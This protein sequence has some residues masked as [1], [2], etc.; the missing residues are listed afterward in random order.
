MKL[1]VWTYEGPPHVGALRVATAMKGLHYVLHAPQGD[2]Y[3]DLLFTMIERRN[4]RPPVTYTT[5]QARD[6]GADTA[7]LF[8]TACLA[9]H[10]RFRPQAMIVG[11]SCTAELIQD[12]PGGMAETMGLPVPVIPLDLPSYQRKENFGADETLF[13]LVRA[14]ARPMD[15]SAHV[16]CNLIGPTALGFRHRDDITEL[17]ALLGDMGIGVNVCAP[18]GA[19]PQ[20]LTRLGAAHFNVLMYPETGE[21]ACRWMERELGQPYTRTVPIGVGATRDFLGE[22]AA[23]TGRSLA[24]DESRLRLP[25]YSAS[26]DSTYLTGKR[27]FIFGD[28]THVASAARI[29]RDEMGFEVAG[30]GC[31]NREQARMIRALARDYG[32]EALITED[33]LEVEARIAELAPEMILGTQMERHIGKRLGIPC[34]VISAPVHVQDFPA[35]YSPQMGIEGANVIFD[36]WVHPLVMG[37]EEHLLTMFRE[38]FE[39]HDDAGASHHGGAATPRVADPAPAPAEAPDTGG[40]VIWL[41]EAER[42]LRKVPFFVRGKARRNTE[43]YASER[44]LTRIGLDTLY[45]AKAHYAR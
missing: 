9:A 17:T 37:L 25:W 13:Q 19:T 39:F 40:E 34:A 14:L 44:G 29:A 31:Y 35:R 24:L 43:T 20:D 23:L 22:V 28:G 42:E 10:D 11:A 41:D 27:V 18:Y 33:Y 1:S 4:H 6:L 32:V 38:D 30:L 21:A 45:D 15:R 7:Q 3:A 12:D 2:T 5:F 8:K 36:T 26:V 16:T